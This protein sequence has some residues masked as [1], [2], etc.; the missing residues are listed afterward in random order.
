MEVAV[1]ELKVPT[2]HGNRHPNGNLSPW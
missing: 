2:A 1:Q